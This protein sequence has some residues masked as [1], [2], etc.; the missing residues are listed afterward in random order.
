MT[1]YELDV[2]KADDVRRFAAMVMERH[3]GLNAVIN[4]AGIMAVEVVLDQ[5]CDLGIVERTVA[6]NLLAP[7][8]L[9]MALLPHLRS[10]DEAAVVTV[11]SGL[12]FVPRS[13]ALTYSAT[14][15]AIH[16]WAQGCA[17]S[18][19]TPASAS[20][21]WC[22]LWSRRTSC[23]DKPTTPAPCRSTPSSRS[24][25]A[26]VRPGNACRSSG[27]PGDVAANRGRS[28]RFEKIFRMTNPA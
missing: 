16:S 14:K 18:C 26:S 1:G 6:A 21:N 13:D 20:W 5:P 4:N 3:P 7:I 27:S 9:T 28:V 2:S 10:Q 17:I 19:A 22:R 11:S 8:R 12:A 23:P 24:G 25:R 15:A